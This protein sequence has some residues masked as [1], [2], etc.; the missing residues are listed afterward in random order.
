MVDFG[1][2]SRKIILCCPPIPYQPS[3]EL[4]AWMVHHG[5]GLL[6]S[7]LLSEDERRMLP[8]RREFVEYNVVRRAR[9]RDEQRLTNTTRLE[10]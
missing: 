7:S 2:G 8:T 6:F 3:L 5:D 9:E 4:T 1:Q 10:K